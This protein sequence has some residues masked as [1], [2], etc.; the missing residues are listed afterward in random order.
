MYPVD[1]GVRP[2]TPREVI[3]TLFNY[4]KYMTPSQVCFRTKCLL[5]WSCLKDVFADHPKVN[6]FSFS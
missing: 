5:E 3:L 6:I 2:S 1:V 4:P